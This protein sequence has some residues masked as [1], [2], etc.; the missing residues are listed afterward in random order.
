[1]KI[2]SASSIPYA[3]LMVAVIWLWSTN[4]FAE[5]V[6]EIK[7]IHTR[8]SSHDHPQALALSLPLVV[9]HH[10]RW[11]TTTSLPLIVPS[12]LSLCY[13]YNCSSTYGCPKQLL[14]FSTSFYG[15]TTP[16]SHVPQLSQNV[17]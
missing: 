7:F 2:G 13:D 9:E 1:M 14:E 16:L 3:V 17:D 6:A 15:F 5:Q 12:T 4:K 11:V 10:G 8:S